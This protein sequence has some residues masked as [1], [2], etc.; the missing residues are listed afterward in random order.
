MGGAAPHAM[1]P[2]VPSSS[3]ST[4][5]RFKLSFKVAT[6]AAILLATIGQ[7]GAMAKSGVKCTPASAGVEKLTPLG[8]I[9]VGYSH[10]NAF[11]SESSANFHLNVHVY[12]C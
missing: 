12:D 1:H 6:V 4:G 8:I 11:E 7:H 3:Y 2:S 9:S 10:P 5:T